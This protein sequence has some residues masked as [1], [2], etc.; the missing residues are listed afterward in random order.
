M[1]QPLEDPKAQVG[2]IAFRV[3]VVRP[4]ETCGHTK[5]YMESF[6]GPQR[7]EPCL[8]CERARLRSLVG[9]L[10]DELVTVEYDSDPPK[11]VADMI[12]EAEEA[13]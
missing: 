5:L 6:L 10:V 11:R 12:E 9:R 2:R 8:F 1:N 13:R 4:E 3:E 7:L